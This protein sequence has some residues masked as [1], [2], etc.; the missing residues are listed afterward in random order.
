MCLECGCGE[1]EHTHPHDHEHPHTHEHPHDHSHQHTREAEAR[2]ATRKVEVEEKLLLKN[3][4]VAERNRAFL[5]ERGVTAVN[6]ISAPGSG[7]TTLLERTLERLRDRVACAVI[8]GDQSTDHDARRLQGKGAPV[9]QIETVSACHLSAEQVSRV[10]P[11]VVPPGVRLLFIEN[12]GN[13]VCPAAFDLGESFKIAL[14]STT[15]GEDK[16]VK[17]PSLFSRAQVAVLTKL[18]LAETLGWDGQLC[19][20]YLQQAHPGIF[21]FELSA[22]TGAG[23]DAWIDYLE[24]LTA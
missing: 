23:M 5:S 1:V 17:Y 16:P 7:K 12:V 11:E 18:D 19:R 24:K 13:L 21:C 9:V 14:L 20:R 3:D 8:A 4:R 15:E 2:T 10:L 22:K 6:L